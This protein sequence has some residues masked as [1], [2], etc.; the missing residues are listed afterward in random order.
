A[1]G[2]IDTCDQAAGDLDLNGIVDP[3]DLALLLLDFGPCPECPTDFDA[4]GTVDNADIA[5]L[6]LNFGPA[7]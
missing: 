2:R 4:S 6:L 1:N 5:L 7:A 3:A